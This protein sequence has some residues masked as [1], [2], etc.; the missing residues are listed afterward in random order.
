MFW[1]LTIM[2]RAQCIWMPSDYI[3]SDPK[4][5]RACGIIINAF[6]GISKMKNVHM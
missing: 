3:T 4:K 2:N 6:Y 5:D 1:A